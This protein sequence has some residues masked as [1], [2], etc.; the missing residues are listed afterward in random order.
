MN[1]LV[2]VKQVPDLSEI[3][4]DAQTH[5]LQRED[6]VSIVNPFDES[7]LYLAIQLK[8]EI[9]DCRI[10]VLS[11]GPACA[12][13]ALR[14]CLAMG[15]D[16][17]YLISGPEFAG[18]DSLTTAYVLS[19]AFH[20]LQA[21]EGK[22]DLIFCGKQTLDGDTGQVGPQLAEFLHLPQA[23]GV[24]EI[25]LQGE[26]VQV[27]RETDDGYEVLSIKYPCLLAISKLPPRSNCPN[28]KRRIAANRAE[29]IVF[30]A[31]HLGICVTQVGINASPTHVKQ[32]SIADRRPHGIKLSGPEEKTA[33]ELS[34]LMIGKD[35][36]GHPAKSFP[37]L[38]LTHKKTS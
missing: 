25:A 20:K 19:C 27:H 11:M 32:I 35:F 24:T 31:N 34:C 3:H 9:P 5:T 18:S 16:Q 1:I 2:C 4:I 14:T 26:Y 12:Q 28:I 22:F 21:L 13:K 29:I 10:T 23:T 33:Q 30:S 7:A 17:A 37:Q 8:K 15:A 6:A 38:D 36:I